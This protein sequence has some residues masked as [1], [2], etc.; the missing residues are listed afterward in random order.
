MENKNNRSAREMLEKIYGKKCMIHQGIKKNILNTKELENIKKRYKGKSIAYQLTYHHL[1][2]KRNGGKATLEN[3]SILCR[4]CHDWLEA[5]SD[6]EREI[7]NNELREYKLSFNV[8]EL[9]TKGIQQA[10]KIIIEEPQEFIEIPLEDNDYQ[11]LEY[12][13]HK[14]KRNERV[15][16]KFKDWSER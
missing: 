6:K 10:E 2:A 8:A 7:V 14:R 1:L 5:L 15:F 3:G 13:E 4:T 16:K 9:T 11:D 12:L